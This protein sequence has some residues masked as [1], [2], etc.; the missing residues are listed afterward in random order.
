M[1]NKA[2]NFLLRL[3]TVSFCIDD[4]PQGNIDAHF[5]L[6]VF[7]FVRHFLDVYRILFNLLSDFNTHLQIP[8][9]DDATLMESSWCFAVL[10]TLMEHVFLKK[11]VTFK[12]V[13]VN[14]CLIIMKD[15]NL[16]LPLAEKYFLFFRN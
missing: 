2:G 9:L 4:V 11:V 12:K 16:Y 1:I 14:V 3:L 13:L 15:L 7:V 6:N 8:C 10:A 5:N